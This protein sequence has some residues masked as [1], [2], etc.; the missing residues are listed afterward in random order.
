MKLR[1]LIC[2][3]TFSLLLE[4]SEAWSQM[5]L[6]V[7]GEAI[8]R[9]Y[10]NSDIDKFAQRAHD[11]FG[12]NGEFGISRCLIP[13]MNIWL[14]HYNSESYTLDEALYLLRMDDDI[15]IAQA[16]HVMEE[17]IVPDDPFFEL[18]WHHEQA[19]DHDIDTP[20]AWDITT[21]GTDASG[22]DI[23]VC[24][25]EING[26]QWN[27][28]DIADNHWVNTNE[29]PDNGVDD[30]ANG[31]VDDYDGWN[32]S[33]GNDN[34]G[35]GDHGTRVSSMIGAKG[36][37]TLGITGVNWDVKLM[38]V[39]I[40]GSNEAAAIEGYAYPLAMRRLYNQS[41]GNEGAFVVAT[42]SSWGTDNGQ[43][44]DAPLWCA[45]YDS[46]GAEG[47]LSCGSTTNN[48]VN[49]DDVGDLP[50]GCPSDYLISVART[51]SQDIRAGGGYGITTI[52]LAAPG[53][54]VYL[55]NNTSYGNTTGTSFSS[56]CVAG[57]IGL[58]YSAP[59]SS[60]AE[61]SISAPA[62]TAMQIREAVLS[63]VDTT[64]QLLSELVSG[65]RLNVWNSLQQVMS[66]CD[67]SLCST[68]FGV[69][70]NSVT[71]TN[72]NVSWSASAT[73]LSFALR[74]RIQGDANWIMIDTDTSSVSLDNLVTCA[75]YEVQVMSFCDGDSSEWS[76]AVNFISEGC[77]ENPGDVVVTNNSGATVTLEWSS[78]LAASGY[79]V[80]VMDS[81]GVEVI[82]TTT[83]ND[84]LTLEGLQNCS[85][86]FVYVYSIC[87]GFPPPP[88]PFVFFSS[89]CDNCSQLEVCSAS[90]SST[91][92]FIQLVSLG[93]IYRE[94]ESDNGYVFVTDQTTDLIRGE[95]YSITLAP[96]YTSGQY[97]ENF[98]VWLDFNSD[99]DFDDSDELAFDAPQPTQ[100]AI[101][102]SISIP[103]SAALGSIRMRVGMAYTPSTIAQEPEA[104]GVWNFGEVEDYCV[105]IITPLELSITDESAEAWY[106]V[107]AN[108]TLNYKGVCSFVRCYDGMGREFVLPVESNHGFTQL[109]VSFLSS[110]IYVLL[111]DKGGEMKSSSFIITR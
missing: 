84:S 7:D 50:T 75:A 3:G 89:G 99:G 10:S 71:G 12:I 35:T 54:A 66:L 109:D 51:N 47:V 23:V 81:G 26:T 43:A 9:L 48:N 107:P 36:N 34:I 76:N 16:N 77:C 80:S 32:A 93:M 6:T 37:N 97:N 18:Q 42:N 11:A 38:Q 101:T 58:I 110:G 44:A 55:A 25:V 83:T 82:S 14:V 90:S 30:D 59:C 92:E 27:T 15:M 91:E 53:D 31:Y 13:S 79:T 24:V 108:A 57:A 106:P 5:A 41:G 98:R 94:S 72:Y 1:C 4:I 65:G 52:D 69:N 87:S 63:G 104:C 102:G 22:H 33:T 45:M 56:P 60:L 86:Y 17:R 2:I 62:Y 8:I 85:Q 61:Q 67:N 70:V 100:Q 105:S 74:Y 103:E 95:S 49:V 40:S 20:Q 64:S 96:G 78:V 21:G 73:A 29:I 28:S 111:F 46:L 88:V 39:Q 19:S 68:P